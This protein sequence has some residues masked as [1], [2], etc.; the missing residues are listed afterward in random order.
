MDLFATLGDMLRPINSPELPP[1][2]W[3]VKDGNISILD[4]KGNANA[5]HYL[6]MMGILSGEDNDELA[7]KLNASLSITPEQRKLMENIHLN[8]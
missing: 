7:D 4:N 2:C 5:P 8:K 1:F 3:G 6:A